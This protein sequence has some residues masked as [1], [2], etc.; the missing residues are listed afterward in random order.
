MFE[1]GKEYHRRTD[2]HE[3]YGGQR[4]GG[5]S[6]PQ[7]YPFIFIFTSD[8]GEQHGYKDEFI[9][10]LFW[11]TGEGQVGDMEMIKGNKA[12]LNHV[13][14]GKKIH[15]FEYT[16]KAFVRYVGAAECLGYKEQIRPD[17]EGNERKVFVFQ[18]DIDSTPA[19]QGTIEPPK[20]R[21]IKEPKG[22][23]KPTLTE[24][25]KS[26]LAVPKN[27]T[28]EEKARVAYQRA[29][30]IKKY[31]LAR[32]NGVCEGCEQ[33]APFMTSKGPYLECHHL[34]RLADGGPDHPDN[35]IALCPNCHRAA[36]HAKN[37]S[38]INKAFIKTVR[39]KECNG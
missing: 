14:T 17:R 23:K 11:Y 4:Q 32:A 8:S 28:K 6:T 3:K 12:I 33:P 26:A 20:S 2:L 25:R 21:E 10:G 1:V 19:N 27:Q 13:E 16:R 36:H 34:Y 29:E 30:A 37:S 9:D 18:L 31:V 5:I 38:I 24:L 35:V 22:S 15:V 7:N 39:I